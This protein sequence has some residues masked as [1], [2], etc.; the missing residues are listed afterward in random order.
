MSPHRRLAIHAAPYPWTWKIGLFLTTLALS[1]FIFAVEVLRRVHC[2]VRP[3]G[4]EVA[5]YAWRIGPYG[6]E[7]YREDLQGGA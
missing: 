7:E 6:P 5:R 4:H 2:P 1:P 3:A